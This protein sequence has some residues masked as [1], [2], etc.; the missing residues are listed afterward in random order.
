[1]KR[2]AKDARF[3]RMIRERD[4][5]TCQRCGAVHPENSRG[6]HCA[7]MFG[8][9]KL[10]TRFDPE[11]AAALCYGCHRWLDTHPDLKREF[12]RERLGEDVFAALELRSNGTKL[13]KG[14]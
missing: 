9:G 11:N 5:F 1:M 3:S 14:A 4:L 6:L 7:H 8:R 10:R 12:F 13:T 2:D